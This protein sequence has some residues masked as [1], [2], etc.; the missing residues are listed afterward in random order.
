MKDDNHSQN[1]PAFSI[2][3]LPPSRWAEYKS[4]RLESVSNS[5]LAFVS[6]LPELIEKPDSYWQ[7]KLADSDRNYTWIRFAELNE[8]G[9]CRI[10]GMLSGEAHWLDRRSD[11]LVLIAMYVTY[12][13]RKLGIATA[14]ITEILKLAKDSGKYKSAYLYVSTSQKQAIRLYEKF[15]FKLV[16]TNREEVSNGSIQ[17]TYGMRLVF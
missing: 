7:E 5:P 16:K 2:I 13:T 12:T 8:K 17:E 14:L 1:K 6:T 3:K 9:N 4:L 10:V 11:E 15:G